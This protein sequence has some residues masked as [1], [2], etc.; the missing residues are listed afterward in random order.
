M[1]HSA[2]GL[3]FCLSLSSGLPDHLFER[4]QQTLFTFNRTTLISF[5]FYCTCH[6]VKLSCLFAYLCSKSM[7]FVSTIIF[8]LFLEQCITYS[9]RSITICYG[10]KIFW[11]L[12][13]RGPEF[14]GGISLE[15][16]AW[17]GQTKLGTDIFRFHFQVEGICPCMRLLWFI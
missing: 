11:L 7:D 6:S 14:I 3:S 17:M 16:V 8:L 13:R 1:K 10:W 12:S 2:S 5:P 4:S 15:P 9:R